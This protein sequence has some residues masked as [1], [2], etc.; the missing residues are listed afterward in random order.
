MSYLTNRI[1]QN[2]IVD[3]NNAILNTVILSGATWNSSGI[4]TSTLGVNS[5]QIIASSTEDLE[6][7]V[8]QGISSTSFQITDT[9]NFNVLKGGF[10]ITVQAVGEY[11][12][13]RAKNVDISGATVTLSTYLCPMA[14]PLPR[15][16]SDR[17]H[18]FVNIQDIDDHFGNELLISPV[19]SM[20]IS[21]PYKLVGAPFGSAPD[22]NFW[23]LSNSGTSSVATIANSKSTLTSGT[24]IGGFG[25]IQSFRSARFLIADPNICRTLTRVVNLS[26]SGCTRRWG[27]FST[28]SSATT[29]PIDG[30]CFELNDANQLSCVCHSGGSQSYSAVNGSFNGDVSSFFMDTD[31]HIYNIIYYVGKVQFII[32]DILIHQFIPTISMLTSTLTL[33]VG[34]NVSN[35][36]TNSGSLELWIGTIKRMGRESSAPLTKHTNGTVTSQ[37]LKNGAGTFKSV[38][39]N[40]WTTATQIVFFDSL[41]SGATGSTSTLAIIRP[42]TEGTSHSIIPFSMTY[43]LDFYVGLTV[44]VT[45]GTGSDLTILLE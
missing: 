39:I 25:Q 2:V 44:Q 32:D 42:L 43:N 36:S 33:P 31:M 24:A 26:V 40:T 19:G 5:I 14:E 16:L 11:V 1:Q 12:R 45:G 23:T 9:Y 22:T 21:Q 13:V 27:A 8:D 17:G 20:N 29:T 18:L 38:H 7:Y 10:G 6:I 30:F 15:S 41:T 37:N 3:T 35:T 34:A 4:G 28:A